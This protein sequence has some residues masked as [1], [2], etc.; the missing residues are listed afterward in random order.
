MEL[1][2]TPGDTRGGMLSILAGSDTLPP[3]V[4]SVTLVIE[5]NVGRKYY[6]K[7]SYHKIISIQGRFIYGCFITQYNTKIPIAKTKLRALFF[8][9]K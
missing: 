7:D 1:R 2:Q 3:D 6:I 5:H 9:H 4:F 8:S